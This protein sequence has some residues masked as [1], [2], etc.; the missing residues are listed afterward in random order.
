[1]I[2]TAAIVVDPSVGDQLTSDIPV[3]CC[4]LR[5]VLFIGN[6]KNGLTTRN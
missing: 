5:V 6:R 1:M 4:W 3:L 2:V